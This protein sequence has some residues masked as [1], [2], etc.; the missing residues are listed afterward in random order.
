MFKLLPVIFILS[1]SIVKGE[2]FIYFKTFPVRDNKYQNPITFIKCDPQS[3]KD[4][5]I[6]HSVKTFLIEKTKLNGYKSFI[7]I[8][9]DKDKILG[10]ELFIDSPPLPEMT[11]G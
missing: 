3:L 11:H 9:L 6:K 4:P 7:I 10:K 2:N 8:E 1:L 5:K